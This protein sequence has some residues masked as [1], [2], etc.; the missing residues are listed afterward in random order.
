[1]DTAILCPPFRAEIPPASYVPSILHYDRS[2]D[3]ISETCSIGNERCFFYELSR[4]VA[5]APKRFA[6][7]RTHVRNKAQPWRRRIKISRGQFHRGACRNCTLGSF[8]N[9]CAQFTDGQKI[10]YP[11]LVLISLIRSTSNF[12]T[13]IFKAP[14]SLISQGVLVKNI[15]P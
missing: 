9:R 5:P 8:A 15:S 3:I 10:C 12:C 11:W 13:A 7:L 2:S 6:T 4:R 1:M 14:S